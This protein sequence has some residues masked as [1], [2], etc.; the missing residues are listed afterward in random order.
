MAVHHKTLPCLP[1]GSNFLAL[2]RLDKSVNN[3]FAS[4]NLW[5]RPSSERDYTKGSLLLKRL[6]D[7]SPTLKFSQA[8][9][10]LL[11]E[12]YILNGQEEDLAK[13]F[14]ILGKQCGDIFH[15]DVPKA[16]GH[17][18]LTTTLPSPKQTVLWS[19]LLSQWKFC[20]PFLKTG[21]RRDGQAQVQAR[22]YGVALAAARWPK[23]KQSLLDTLELALLEPPP[24]PFRH[25]DLSY[26]DAWFDP[27]HLPAS[28][29]E[30]CMAYTEGACRIIAQK[31]PLTELLEDR[32]VTGFAT[33]SNLPPTTFRPSTKHQE[34]LLNQSRQARMT[35]LYDKETRKRF[36][37]SVF[38]S[39]ARRLRDEISYKEAFEGFA[40]FFSLYQACRHYG[41]GVEDDALGEH[42][43]ACES[44]WRLVR[45]FLSILVH[46]ERS[47]KWSVLLLDH[48]T[49]SHPLT[50]M[51]GAWEGE[52]VQMFGK[53]EASGSM[54]VH[55]LTS[56]IMARLAKV[57]S[58]LFSKLSQPS[59]P[60]FRHPSSLVWGLLFSL[61]H[62]HEER[63]HFGVLL[64]SW[65]EG[66]IDERDHWSLLISLCRFLTEKGWQET[67]EDM[68]GEAESRRSMSTSPE[69]DEPRPE[70]PFVEP[71]AIVDV[72]AGPSTGFS[73]K[74]SG[75]ETLVSL[76]SSMRRNEEMVG[77][78]G[79]VQD[80]IVHGKPRGGF[81]DGYVD[82]AC[83]W[84]VVPAS[85]PDT[86]FGLPFGPFVEG[87]LR[88]DTLGS[89][90]MIAPDILMDLEA[91]SFVH[92]LF[93][94]TW[95]EEIQPLL[96][97]HLLYLDI[98]KDRAD[99]A[100]DATAM[101]KQ[102]QVGIHWNGALLSESLKLRTSSRGEIGLDEATV[103][104][105]FS[106][107]NLAKALGEVF[108]RSWSG[109]ELVWHTTGYKGP[110]NGGSTLALEDEEGVDLYA[111]KIIEGWHRRDRKPLPP[112]AYHLPDCTMEDKAVDPF[113]SDDDNLTSNRRYNQAIHKELEKFL[114][115][116]GEDTQLRITLEDQRRLGISGKHGEYIK[117]SASHD[118]S[119]R[120]AYKY[121]EVTRK[122]KGLVPLEERPTLY[123]T[124]E[125]PGKDG[126]LPYP[127]DFSHEEED[128][129]PPEFYYL[130]DNPLEEE[131]DEETK[132]P[133]PL[134]SKMTVVEMNP[135]S[136]P[137]KRK[138]GIFVPSRHS[139]G[140]TQKK[141]ASPPNGHIKN[142][143]TDL[144]APT[145]STPPKGS[146]SK[147]RQIFQEWKEFCHTTIEFR[148]YATGG[149]FRVLVHDL[150]TFPILLTR[151]DPAIRASLLY[152]GTRWYWTQSFPKV[153]HKE[154]PFLALWFHCASL[155]WAHWVSGGS[156]G[157]PQIWKDSKGFYAA[158]PLPSS[159]SGTLVSQSYVAQGYTIMRQTPTH[160][161]GVDASGPF[162]SCL[163]A[164]YNASSVSKEG[165]YSMLYWLVL[166]RAFGYL[167]STRGMGFLETTSEDQPASLIPITWDLKPV[168]TEEEPEDLVAFF[169][170]STSYTRYA[171]DPY[172]H[173]CLGRL[174]G[175]ERDGRPNHVRIEHLRDIFAEA[176]E[177]APSLGLEVDPKALTTLQGLCLRL[178]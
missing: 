176:Y 158:L 31:F 44:L 8:E 108:G 64:E 103:L 1:V 50:R 29:R 177:L 79:S 106:Y 163:N 147:K 129:E 67:S 59:H 12:A 94:R 165:F 75:S 48:S 52:W 151:T 104:A 123:E 153:N 17:A 30:T 155:T 127:E 32:S 23:S 93:D 112:Q 21:G 144:P 121:L 90:L 114:P 117:P 78:T 82:L 40:R 139:V 56:I 74:G 80:L 42:S 36:I 133:K 65:L 115:M 161:K 150:G 169:F 70:V 46:P 130:E 5:L 116:E 6:Q 63:L 111:K 28:I 11:L 105:T 86:L 73:S 87:F 157:G 10:L 84:V 132:K 102:I 119:Y 7:R 34:A 55:S 91:P 72:E 14:H 124:F 107:R 24:C 109:P 83:R 99:Q 47:S 162:F 118:K 168:D 136:P 58:R 113:D 62:D 41:A 68:T 27:A 53:L 16:I 175:V 49:S 3:R 166:P 20:Q 85:P 146:K 88:M 101:E 37:P 60:F 77:I 164:I 89:P 174:V 134:S 170:G 140:L 172:L 95:G 145:V 45:Y 141:V 2:N 148:P 96:G 122:A 97:P 143:V 81:L 131:E 110:M 76:S 152:S 159:P 126:T 178:K 13:I 137:E 149:S 4:H 22:M 18:I 51:F 9:R 69:S 26:W 167:A 19:T 92:T 98:P 154:D 100:Y 138:R 15:V 160:P 142:Y 38:S 57:N 25:P 35:P 128:E 171:N 135:R 39:N 61:S 120:L 156:V 71:L 173:T 43:Q 125:N 33:T 66:L 54:N